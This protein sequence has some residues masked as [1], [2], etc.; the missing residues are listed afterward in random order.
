PISR[1][2]A[3]L[4]GG[5]VTLER[6]TGGGGACFTLRLPA[7]TPMV[8]APHDQPRAHD[9]TPP[10]P[11]PVAGRADAGRGLAEAGATLLRE[12][13]PTVAEFVRR[14][15]ADTALGIPGSMSDVEVADHLGTLVTDVA[16]SL[17]IL[18]AAGGE[19]TEL[20]ADGTRIQRVIGE[21][22]GAQ[23]Q[24]LGWTEAQLAREVELVAEVCHQALTRSLGSDERASRAGSRALQR[25][26]DERTRACLTGFRDAAAA[27]A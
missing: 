15:R 22:H 10:A 12:I 2:L 25:L 13:S 11:D 18:G 7:G 24:R 26:L 3:R 21:L 14:A 17:A 4:M 19:A 16:N 20:L 23:R 6:G 1:R 8:S 5:D 9:E 27:G